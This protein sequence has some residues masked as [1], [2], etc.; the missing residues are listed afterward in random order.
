M[1]GRSLTAAELKEYLKPSAA[2]RGPLVW[3]GGPR[4]QGRER[5]GQGSPPPLDLAAAGLRCWRA[6]EEVHT[7]TWTSELSLQLTKCMPFYREP[8]RVIACGTPTQVQ[9]LRS[10]RPYPRALPR[11]PCASA[12]AAWP[13][14]G[15]P[16]LTTYAPALR[17]VARHVDLFIRPGGARRGS[18]CSEARMSLVGG[19]LLS[20][21]TASQVARLGW[22][23]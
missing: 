7:F 14:S 5:R 1:L 8:C 2:K 12:S 4:P 15:C 10:N 19:A 18:T 23:T 3:A 17:T 6:G 20:Y 16:V 22:G 21:R 9:S 11:P 13:L